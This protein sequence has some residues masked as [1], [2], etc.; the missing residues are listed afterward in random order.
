[1][2]IKK[3]ILII[4]Y[5]PNLVVRL[6]IFIQC[7]QTE[8]WYLQ[9]DSMSYPKSWLK[10]WD[11]IASKNMKSSTCN[12]TQIPFLVSLVILGYWQ[13][14]TFNSFWN[15]QLLQWNIKAVI[16]FQPSFINQKFKNSICTLNDSI[17]IFI[18]YAE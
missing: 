2:N 7:L 8:Q 16:D 4:S 13:M 15:W 17:F 6:R 9:T 1:M 5:D 10:A 12:F 18:I 3:V 11:A 14:K